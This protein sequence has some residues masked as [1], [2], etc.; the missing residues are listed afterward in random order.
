MLR[1]RA[2][3]DLFWSGYRSERPG[4]SQSSTGP[5]GKLRAGPRSRGQATE[6]SRY[7]R[8]GLGPALLDAWGGPSYPPIS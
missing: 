6:N 1:E 5:E 2:G 4:W 8:I 7:S 3:K